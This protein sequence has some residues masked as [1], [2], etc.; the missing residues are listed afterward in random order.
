MRQALRRPRPNKEHYMSLSILN[1][2]PG[3]AAQNSLATTHAGL[4][5]TLEQL[6]SGLRINSGADDAAGL[7]IANSL[8]SNVTALT[9]SAQNANDGVSKLQ[10]ADG[11]L[12]PVR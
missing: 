3:L 5:T 10:V 6:S 4:N 7:S 9:Q 8:Q 11:S 12:S 1:N 2:I